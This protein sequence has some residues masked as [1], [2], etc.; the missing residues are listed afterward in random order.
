MEIV[1]LQHIKIEDPGHIK[2]LMISE[3]NH[4]TTFLGFAREYQDRELVDQQW[5]ALV[6][7][8]AEMM[9]NRGTE[10]KVHG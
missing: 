1:I 4:Y 3:A 7:F 2:D 9:K 5:N 6:A 8:E 10:A